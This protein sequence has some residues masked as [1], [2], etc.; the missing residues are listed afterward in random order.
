M[1]ASVTRSSVPPECR[2]RCPP[3]GC[4]ERD[5]AEIKVIQ[6]AVRPGLA[7][8]KGSQMRAM[9]I[10]EEGEVGADVQIGAQG[11]QDDFHVYPS[12]RW[13]SL[14]IY[15]E[16]RRGPQHERT[17][18]DQDDDLQLPVVHPGGTDTPATIKVDNTVVRNNFRPT[19][20]TR[21]ASTKMAILKQIPA[22]HISEWRSSNPETIR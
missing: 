17:P 11:A 15:E 10:V 9:T 19:S 18:C 6:L 12:S 16:S 7:R 1:T 21:S 2:R 20:E 14:P 8:R 4:G 3:S 5:E 13:N 22:A